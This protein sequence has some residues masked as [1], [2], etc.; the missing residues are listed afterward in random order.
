MGRGWLER[1]HR[2]L[3]PLPESA[4]H[5]WLALNEGSFALN[6]ADLEASRARPGGMADVVCGRVPDG[7]R[8]LD[9]AS[10]IAGAE[11]LQ[12]PLSQAWALCYARSERRVPARG[13]E[14]GAKR[15][16]FRIAYSRRPADS[17]AR[18]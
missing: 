11:E 9:E 5:G 2:L 1:A 6:V 16:F 14:R 13:T 3:D 10:A 4:D 17:S 8:R 12:L 7:M 18:R 15:T